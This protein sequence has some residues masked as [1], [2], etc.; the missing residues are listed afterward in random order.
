MSALVRSAGLVFTGALLSGP[1]ATLIVS[2]VAP[3][4]PWE[5]AEAFAARDEQSQLAASR[6]NPVRYVAHVCE[7]VL[8][9]IED[10]Q[11]PPG[12]HALTD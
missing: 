2:I 8:A 4:P 5:G 11:K 10:D 7:Q 3:Q 6:E 9:V 12:G 1:L